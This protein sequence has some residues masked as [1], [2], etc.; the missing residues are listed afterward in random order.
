VIRSIVAFGQEKIF[1]GIMEAR[2]RLDSGNP[3]RDELIRMLEN[4]MLHYIGLVTSDETPNVA[5]IMFQE[6]LHPTK[7]FSIF[8][9]ELLKE[10]HCVVTAIVARLLKLRPDSQEAILNAHAILGQVMI[11]LAGR[12]LILR[13]LGQEKFTGDDAELLQTIMQQHIRRIF[14]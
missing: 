12:A 11:F 14:K 4:L 5:R 3:S 2:K 1:P 10:E 7:A 9:E 6:Q 8:Y 13:R